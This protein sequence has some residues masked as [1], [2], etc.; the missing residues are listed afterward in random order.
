LQASIHPC[1]PDHASIPS[2]SIHAT[3]SSGIQ[4]P[5]TLSQLEHQHKRYQEYLQFANIYP[6]PSQQ[7]YKKIY[8]AA[9]RLQAERNLWQ[10]Q[11]NELFSSRDD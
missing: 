8:A 1:T 10:Q 4:T 2:S 9:R 7:R 11:Y 3:L 5:T 6:L